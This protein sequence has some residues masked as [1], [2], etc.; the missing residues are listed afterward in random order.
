MNSAEF[1]TLEEAYGAPLERL[2]DTSF[3]VVISVPSTPEERQNT[4][5]LTEFYYT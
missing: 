2:S 4:G 1:P 5:N 3:D